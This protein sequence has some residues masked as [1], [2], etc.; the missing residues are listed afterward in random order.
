MIS[1]WVLFILHS[2]PYTSY[3]QAFLIFH[4]DGYFQYIYNDRDLD[5]HPRPPAPEIPTRS[6][7]SNT[8]QQH[9]G[10]G[11]SR[12][13]SHLN[14]HSISQLRHTS[15]MREKSLD[16]RSNGEPAERNL[17]YGQILS[18]VP[19][20]SNPRTPSPRRLNDIKEE[21]GTNSFLEPSTA[22]PSSP[23]KR[24]RSPAKQLFGQQGWLGRSTSM[25]ELPSDEHRRAGIKHWGGK[26]KQR[27]EEIVS[28]LSSHTK[29]RPN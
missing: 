16:Y 24:S 1:R 11:Q 3:K 20:C 15:L 6:L 25:R 13:E 8:Y 21:Q 10:L 28:P 22:F 17:H 9:M 23:I 26:L 14:H 4:R 7:S 18:A 2:V 5:Q 19:I 29:N 27:I 12:S